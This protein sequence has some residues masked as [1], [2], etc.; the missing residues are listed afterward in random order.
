[1]RDHDDALAGK[2]CAVVERV[3]ARPRSE[4]AAVYPEK[5]R[6]FARSRR[7][8]D[9][10]RQAVLAHRHWNPGVDARCPG[11]RAG[12]MR[13]RIRLLSLTPAHRGI[14]LGGFQRARAHRRQR[15]RDALENA[16]IAFH[17]PFDRAGWR[18]ND[19]TVFAIRMELASFYPVERKST[20]AKAIQ[21]AAAIETSI[22]G[23]EIIIRFLRWYGFRF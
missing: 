23:S 13:D 2:L 7:S 17:L 6:R 21:A 3:P 11:F 15:I 18:L 20:T 9:I 19:R 4:C 16:Q 12:S 1:M 14:G 5:D 22:R 8:P 10:Q